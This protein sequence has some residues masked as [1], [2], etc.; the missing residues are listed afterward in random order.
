MIMPLSGKLT[1]EDRSYTKVFDIKKYSE[2]DAEFMDLVEM[3]MLIVVNTFL[4]SESEN[5]SKDEIIKIF[6][7]RIEI[8]KNGSRKREK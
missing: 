7:K 1:K 8:L 6:R 2:N 5:L 4:K 3:T